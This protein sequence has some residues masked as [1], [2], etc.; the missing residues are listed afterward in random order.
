MGWSRIF[1]ERGGKL[2][3]GYQNTPGTLTQNIRL[4]LPAA[5]AVLSQLGL[6]PIV[7]N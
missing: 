2:Y 7:P 5:N 4:N 6:D 1:V 3:Y